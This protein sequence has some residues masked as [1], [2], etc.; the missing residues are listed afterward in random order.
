MLNHCWRKNDLPI[1]QAVTAQRLTIV[2][3]F[4]TCATAREQAGSNLFTLDCLP[5]R[6]LIGWETLRRI[7]HLKFLFRFVRKTRAPSQSLSLGCYERI[8]SSA[9]G[10]LPLARSP[11]LSQIAMR[12]DIQP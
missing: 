11:M 2:Y 1:T 3:L 5:S 9:R 12:T 10:C 7:K 6:R 4:M 8:Q